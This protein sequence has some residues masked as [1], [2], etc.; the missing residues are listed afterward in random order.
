[1]L[2]RGYSDYR[3]SSDEREPLVSGRMLVITSCPQGVRRAT[4]E[5]ALARNR[6]VL[7]LASEV[8][9]PYVAEGSSLAVLVLERNANA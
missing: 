2:A 9:V 4:R 7:M 5:T 3:P 1:M 8:V 6:L